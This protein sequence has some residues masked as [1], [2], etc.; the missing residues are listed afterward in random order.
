MLKE[1]LIRKAQQA[2]AA[3]SSH[4]ARAVEAGAGTKV[5][6]AS[7]KEASSKRPDAWKKGRGGGWILVFFAVV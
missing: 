2:E 3:E 6:K 7:A 4:A 1:Q 5:T